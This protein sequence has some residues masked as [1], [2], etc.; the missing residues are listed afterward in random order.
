VEDLESQ[1]ATSR[2]DLDNRRISA[3]KAR[4]EIR[5][6]ET[7]IQALALAAPRDGILVVAENPWEDRKFEVGDTAYAGLTVM[8]IP[9]LA[10]MRVEAK[11]SDVDDG[12][13]AIGMPAT[14]YL[15]MVPGVAFPGRVVEL[16]PVAQEATRRSMRRA[17]RVLVDLEKTDPERMRPGMSVRVEVETARLADALVAPRAGL[18][19]DASPPKAR[20]DG[21]GDAEVRLGACSATDCVV[22]EGLE[23]GTRLR[24]PA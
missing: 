2:A 9:D 12:R 13:V 7:A 15:D 3:E 5:A 6:A 19:L 14:C 10:A 20:L 18:D 11:L 1:R 17:F 21:G 4:R 16:T 24:R 23:E 8:R 22:L